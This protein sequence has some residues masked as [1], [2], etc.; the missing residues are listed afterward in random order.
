MS[1]KLELVFENELAKNVT[2]SLDNPVY[3]V[4]TAAISAA[5]DEIIAQNAFT[6]SGG[7]LVAKKSARV[8][9]RTVET[10]EF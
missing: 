2:I 7:N 9:D 4:D 1:K 5:M 10:I 8:V 3:P 6:S